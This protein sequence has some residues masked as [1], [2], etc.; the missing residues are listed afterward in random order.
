MPG[1][2]AYTIPLGSLGG[3]FG[4]AFSPNAQLSASLPHGDTVRLW[5]ISAF[6]NL[7]VTLCADVGAPARQEWKQYAAGEP[8]PRVC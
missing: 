4:V 6:I 8:Q 1:I 5:H 2:P 3:M 7:C